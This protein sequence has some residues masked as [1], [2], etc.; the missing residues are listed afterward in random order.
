MATVPIVTEVT[1]A[2]LDALVA[3][4]A[5]EEGLQYKVTDKNWLLVATSGNTYS[6]IARKYKTCVIEISQQG[7]GTEPVNTIL[8]NDTNIDFS[9]TR[10]SQNTYILL[11]SG[12][13]NVNVQF[14]SMFVGS[15]SILHTGGPFADDIVFL[16]YDKF[17]NAYDQISGWL[18]L[19]IYI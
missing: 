19:R 9:V 8:E 6:F 11:N 18:E 14:T 10:F 7:M 16:P 1:K 17:G 12:N 5:L 4:N 15:V 2:Q 13:L 3:S